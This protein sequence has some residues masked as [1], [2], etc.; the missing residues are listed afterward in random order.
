MARIW[1]F[2]A[3]RQMFTV[4]YLKKLLNYSKV[5]KNLPIFLEYFSGRNCQGPKSCQ[6]GKIS[7]NLVT[8]QRNRDSENLDVD[9]SGPSRAPALWVEPEPV[10]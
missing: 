5:A 7:P 3:F 4:L 1:S 6:N 10:L 8:L 9:K 2:L